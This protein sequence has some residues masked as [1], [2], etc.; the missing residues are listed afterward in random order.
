[1]LP[2]CS[3]HAGGTVPMGMRSKVGFCP[4]RRVTGS[5]WHRV[6][7]EVMFLWLKSAPGPGRRGAG[8]SFQGQ[9]CRAIQ[10]WQPFRAIHITHSKSHLHV[11]C[12]RSC[13]DL[14][15]VSCAPV[16]VQDHVLPLS[17]TKALSSSGALAF[18]YFTAS[19]ISVI[20][21]PRT[22]FEF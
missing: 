3:P 11:Q 6:R 19:P 5:L 18:I 13:D 22:G 8:L 21:T 1:M 9:C 2:G 17:P 15:G 10:Q 14:T 7:G 12:P 20:I 4:V 16:G